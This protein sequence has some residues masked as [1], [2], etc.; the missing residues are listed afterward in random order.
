MAVGEKA[1]E[2]IKTQAEAIT[3]ADIILRDLM[4]PYATKTLTMR[5]F[6][7]LNVSDRVR[8]EPNNIH[9]SEALYGAIM[10]VTHRFEQGNAS[11]TVELRGKPAS[12]HHKHI[13]K[14]AGPRTGSY[15]PPGRLA[16]V[17]TDLGDR[18]RSIPT[19][20]QIEQGLSGPLV[21]DASVTTPNPYFSVHLDY[22]N[23][24]FDGWTPDTGSTWGSGAAD[25]V[26][27]STTSH[28]S[29]DRSLV[30][31]T[32]NAAVKTIILQPVIQGQ[33]IRL[34][35]RWKG[36]N[37]A[38]TLAGKVRFFD[39]TRTLIS[40]GTAFTKA[41]ISAG[42]FQT[43]E[44]TVSPPA[45]ARF[46]VIVLERTTA[47][48]GGSIITIDRSWMTAAN[49]QFFA[50]LPTSQTAIAAGTATDVELDDTQTETYDYCGNFSAAAHTFTA[51]EAGIYR[52]EG[53]ITFSGNPSGTKIDNAHVELYK[54]G[55]FWLAVESVEYDG[56]GSRGTIE[57]VFV[58]P[59]VRILG[60][61]VIKMVGYVNTDDF[62]IIAG[63]AST[64]LSG[65]LVRGRYS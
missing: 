30:L 26:Y 28:E 34:Y 53:K 38:D 9:Y 19:Q 40:T 64:W 44:G 24:C 46:A 55:A 33:C 62:D 1:T 12:G 5:N 59:P 42:V 10:T 63:V 61:D 20:V 6:F 49:T 25:D 56:G 31:L 36:D 65:E 18:A 35:A 37:I 7:E 57:A 13:D 15:I 23:Q 52:F 45:N 43:D 4:E 39:S 47:P 3:M 8:F 11:T 2:H 32:Q 29:G 54:N 41:A 27:W 17:S 22:D 50:Y 21:T 51:P 58:S 60:G 16:D 48:V 14:G